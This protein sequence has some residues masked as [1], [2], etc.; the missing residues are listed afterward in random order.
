MIELLAGKHELMRMLRLSTVSMAKWLSFV[1]KP[2]WSVTLFLSFV[3]IPLRDLLT[4]IPR[5]R[6]V[7]NKRLKLRMRS[8]N[9]DSSSLINRSR[10]GRCLV[11]YSLIL[12]KRWPRNTRWTNW[13][14]PFDRYKPRRWLPLLRTGRLVLLV[15]G[16]LLLVL[17]E[18]PKLV[19]LY[20]GL[21]V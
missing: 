14:K 7:L 5:L 12:A 8:G 17:W 1:R 18:N 19:I 11:V 4:Y 21:L 9:W 6:Q 13:S 10:R 15:L 3:R 2:V 20:L 16:Q